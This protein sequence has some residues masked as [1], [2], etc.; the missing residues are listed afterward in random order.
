DVLQ[1]IG[2]G[3]VDGY[4]AD[5]RAGLDTHEVDRAERTARIADRL[6]E[7]RE[8]AW[9]VVEP[10]PQRAAERRGG[11]LDHRRTTPA[12]AS[13]A[14]AA[15][16]YPASR[17]TSSVCSPTRGGGDGNVARA[18]SNESG[19]AGSL[20]SGIAGCGSSWSILSASVCGA[21]KTSATS[22]TGAA[23]TP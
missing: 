7:P 3:G 15:S 12:A 19:S 1:V 11:V 20:S 14:I 4:V 6:R 10:H 13:S 18:R 21:A 5:L 16:S 23:G 22:A 2:V 17:S 9:C 8:R